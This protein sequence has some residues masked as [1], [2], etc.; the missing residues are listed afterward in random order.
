METSYYWNRNLIKLCETRDLVI[1]GD[2][3]D[4]A[5]FFC[6]EKK[7]LGSLG[8]MWELFVLLF[9]HITS[10]LQPH[11]KGLCPSYALMYTEN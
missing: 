9:G 4:V 3:S 10:L 2:E 11:T 1:D 8:N 6:A 5:V 7:N